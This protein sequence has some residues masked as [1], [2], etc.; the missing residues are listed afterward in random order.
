MSAAKT[1]KLRAKSQEPKAGF[2]QKS[3][4]SGGSNSLVFCG[5]AG[6]M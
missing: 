2:K 4:R 5:T 3:H 1:E 6:G